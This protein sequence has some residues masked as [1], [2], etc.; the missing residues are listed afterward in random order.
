MRKSTSRPSRPRRTNA[1]SR[2]NSRARSNTRSRSTTKRRAPLKRRA[3]SRSTKRTPYR[4]TKNRSRSK[5]S[6][7]SNSSYSSYSS[8]TSEP[9]YQP[10][11]QPYNQPIPAPAQN[12]KSRYRTKSPTRARGSVVD[13]QVEKS[14][15]QFN[16]LIDKGHFKNTCNTISQ[17]RY[18]FNTK[19]VEVNNESIRWALTLCPYKLIAIPI[20]ISNVSGQTGHANMLLINK[21]LSTW[22]IERFEPHGVGYKLIE[23][24]GE[25]V[26]NKI[27]KWLDVILGNMKQPYTY[28][29]PIQVCPKPGIQTRG[30]E[31][32]ELGGFCQ[33]WVLVYFETRLEHP[34]LSAEEL[35]NEMFETD[36][37]ELYE[38]IQDYVT[39]INELEIS[40]EYKVFTSFRSMMINSFEQHIKTARELQLYANEALD[41]LSLTLFRWVSSIKDSQT[42]E[43]A[44]NFLIYYG[45]RQGD[46]KFRFPIEF[47]VQFA[48]AAYKKRLPLPAY[49]TYS[50][51]E[52]DATKMIKIALDAPIVPD[53]EVP[54][55]Y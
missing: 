23:D 44:H 27:V 40:K 39:F 42:A 2:S 7:G 17:F 6:Y 25:E 22:E 19:V 3:S 29:T 24:V 13:R 11:Y 20:G 35:L 34:E 8:Q 4:S 12:R 21:N 53:D 30:E 48:E 38:Y 10:Y 49:S 37:N 32:R 15:Y 31:G 54:G 46:T 45:A 50:Y 5:R 43:F 28:K 41:K 36:P 26:D 1:R 16:Y 55:T 47:Y 52:E 14:V 9:Y 51:T 33:T 18:D